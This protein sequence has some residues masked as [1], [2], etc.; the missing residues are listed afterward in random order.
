M[1]W[2]LSWEE[3]ACSSHCSWLMYDT[4]LCHGPAKVS[5]GWALFLLGLGSVQRQ[6][7]GVCSENRR[8]AAALA[9]LSLRWV[10]P[11]SQGGVSAGESLRP[12]SGHLCGILSP[13]SG[14]GSQVCPSP[15]AAGALECAGDE[16]GTQET[17]SPHPTDVFLLSQSDQAA[18]VPVGLCTLGDW[19]HC[20]YFMQITP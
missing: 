18:A 20:P 15:Y 6:R 5:R 8:G 19:H 14:G 17:S 9:L 11:L 16:G 7:V 13:F 2:G 12:W 4:R 3:G 10:A 1:K